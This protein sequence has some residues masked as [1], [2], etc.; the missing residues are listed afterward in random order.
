M[1]SSKGFV[2]YQVKDL[3]CQDS[4]GGSVLCKIEDHWD[5]SERRNLLCYL[6]VQCDVNCLNSV[7]DDHKGRVLILQLYIIKNIGP[8]LM[9]T[10]LY[11]HSSLNKSII[12]LECVDKLDLDVVSTLSTKYFVWHPVFVQRKFGDIG[13]TV[14]NQYEG[15]IYR[16]SS[17]ADIVN[18]HPVPGDGVVKGLKQVRYKWVKGWCKK[19]IWNNATLFITFV[20]LRKFL[21]EYFKSIWMWFLH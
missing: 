14:K 18:A 15:G 16:I 1:V 17:W 11:W 19:T 7:F 12:M 5:L 3:W 6:G 2:W 8:S 9:A 4:H 13:K 10:T 21:G 20:S